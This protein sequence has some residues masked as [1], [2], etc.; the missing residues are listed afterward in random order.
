MKKVIYVLIFLFAFQI[1]D[2]QWQSVSNGLG[3]FSFQNFDKNND[4]LLICSN[5][6]IFLSKNYGD[7]W[8]ET[9]SIKDEY[10][11]AIEIKCVKF[12]D[13]YLIAGTKK[14]IFISKDYGKTWEAKNNTFNISGNVIPVIN[15]ILIKDNNIFIGTNNGVY[16]SNDKCNNWISKNKRLIIGNSVLNTNIM[17]FKNNILIITGG[18]YFNDSGI[19]FS[20]DFGN[21]WEK[22][23]FL[24]ASIRTLYTF[25]DL[26]LIGADN[27]I[28]TSNNNGK[29]FTQS[30]FGRTNSIT[31]Y[32]NI[33]LAAKDYEGLFYSNSNG[34]KWIKNDM[35]GVDELPRQ[36]VSLFTNN[37]YVFITYLNGKNIIY[38]LKLKE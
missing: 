2:A 25:N 15:C 6:K 18:D 8:E 20:I 22:S 32:K 23:S 14:G 37:N 28:F 19:Y 36:A 24:N 7:N 35:I 33:L 27:G 9:Q 21:T 13:N 17:T 16:L 29:S 4:Y 5:W 1:G 34:N 3:L 10:G 31:S 12:L 26:I 11:S 38:R 30:D